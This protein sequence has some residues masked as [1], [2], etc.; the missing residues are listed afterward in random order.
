[1]VIHFKYSSVYRQPLSSFSKSLSPQMDF[2]SWINANLVIVEYVCPQS[3]L[4]FVM[5][6]TVAHQ[7]PLSMGFSRKQYRSELPFPTPG[8]LPNSGIKPVSLVSPPLASGLYHCTTWEALLLSRRIKMRD[9]LCH[10]DADI[11]PPILF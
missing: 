10:Y 8:D 5:L 2:C 1:M 7:A 3:C 6:W 4:T 9:I 11:I